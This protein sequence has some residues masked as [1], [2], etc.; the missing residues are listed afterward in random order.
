[1]NPK[2][3]YLTALRVKK[4]DIVPVSLSIGPSNAKRWIGRDDWQAVLEAH[5][6]VGSIPAQDFGLDYYSTNTDSVFEIEWPDGW[7]ETHESVNA[8]DPNRATIKYRKIRTPFGSLKSRERIDRG[9]Y[10]YGQTLEPLIK[11]HRDYRVYIEYIN[12][13]LEHVSIKDTSA[14]NSEISRMLGDDGVWVTWNIHSFYQYFWTLRKVQDFLLDFYEVPDLMRQLMEATWRLN[15]KYIE[16]YNRSASPLLICNLSGASTSIIS[17]DFFRQWVL[18][19]LERMVE[20]IHPD[21]F[22][23]F[24]LTGKVK[25][26]DSINL[27]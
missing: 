17:P 10:I 19:E 24:H 7:D 13:W 23:G 26:I 20:A 14:E 22:I 16:V 9:E 5:K 15:E 4:P 11:T 27:F 21:K 8:D 2:E 25:A 3:R 18:P 1:M 6:F 12:Q